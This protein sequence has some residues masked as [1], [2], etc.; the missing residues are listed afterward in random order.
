MSSDRKDA[1]TFGLAEEVAEQKALVRGL[2][3]GFES[4][5]PES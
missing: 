4:Q 3:V 2:P 1:G 5:L